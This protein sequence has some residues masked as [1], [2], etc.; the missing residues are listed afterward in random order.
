MARKKVA[1]WLRAPRVCSLQLERLDLKSEDIG[2]AQTVRK[3]AECQANAFRVPAINR[4]GRAYF[5]SR[6]VPSVPGM[7]SR[8]L[9]R[10]AQDACLE[11]GLQ[12]IVTINA[13]G[14][15]LSH[16]L[17]P[18]G[19]CKER[20]SGP[21]E[22]G[23][24]PIYR[25]CL[26]GAYRDF[27]LRAVGE[28][29]SQFRTDGCV[30]LNTRVRRCFCASCVSKYSHETDEDLP[31]VLS[32]TSDDATAAYLHWLQKETEELRGEIQTAVNS[33]AEGTALFFD[34]FPETQ[35]EERIC[36]GLWVS[37]EDE[38]GEVRPLWTTGELAGYSVNSPGPVLTKVSYS[39]GGSRCPQ[40]A[41]RP[42]AELKVAMAQVLAGGCYPELGNFPLRDFRSLP[43]AA[44]MFALLKR[45]AGAFD[46]QACEPTR[47]L[48]LPQHRSLGQPASEKARAE[49]AS[50]ADSAE[51]A[52]PERPGQMR[53]DS[54]MYLALL[55]AG[56]PVNLGA[57]GRFLRQLAG[58]AVL[59]LA[60]ER[61]MNDRTVQAVESFVKAGGGL[62]ATYE[63]SLYDE[64]GQ[65]REN[66]G[67]ADVF[68]A[69]YVQTHPKSDDPGHAPILFTGHE[70]HPVTGALPAGLVL[71]N[72]EARVACLD[73]A[74]ASV[75]ASFPE[76][77][78]DEDR[79][80]TRQ[81]PA[82]IVNTYG[83]GRVVYLPWQPELVYASHGHRD[84]G[85]LIREA[86]YWVSHD[87]NP[88]EVS[89]PGT[90]AVS[91]FQQPNRYLIH[92]VNLSADL[93]REV[94]RVFPVNEA[95]VSLKLGATR[96]VTN[97]RAI[98]SGLQVKEPVTADQIDISVPELGE[99]EVLMVEF[100]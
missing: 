91:L 14:I 23:E 41:A 72:R 58:Q 61:E 73:Q 87:K 90:V 27:F 19:A 28:I 70:P 77:N 38:H 89:S 53:N 11:T 5:V 33:Y 79:K 8:N 60:N 3:A 34:D 18:E 63:T 45:A 65:K 24:P 83:E 44:E 71:P 48:L 13:G 4:Q 62:V 94:D 85:F 93:S 36:D 10:E 20:G 96:T 74:N 1:D 35:A 95:N 50:S 9:I 98:V 2:V 97:Q 69:D 56:I 47:F 39:V 46:Y 25:V 80:A 88:V 84:A 21:V 7:G 32:E 67:L 59:C 37:S 82:V 68:G 100:E 81:L 99:Y 92:L 12:L 64:N 49:D 16:P 6:S 57:S 66:F 86:I 78:E 15:D 42:G 55:R 22:F 43:A 51:P 17:A 29:F 76:R 54:A 52:P 26:L 31:E 75:L 40:S 30:F